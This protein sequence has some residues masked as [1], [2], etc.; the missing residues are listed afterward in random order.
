MAAGFT[1]SSPECGYNIRM[2][3]SLRVSGGGDSEGRLP[4]EEGGG[5]LTPN[6]KNERQPAG[7]MAGAGSKDP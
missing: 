7:P 5:I 4:G 6:E 3:I 2:N 1:L